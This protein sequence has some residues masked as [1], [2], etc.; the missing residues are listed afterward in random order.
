MRDPATDLHAY[1]PR[2]IRLAIATGI[3]AVITLLAML[4][5]DASAGRG[6]NQDPVG[7][8][9]VVFLAIAIFVVTTAAAHGIIGA[10]RRPRG[11]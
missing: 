2:L 8:S 5:I 10:L 9:S 1:R 7:L 11:T 4:A 6:P 3:G